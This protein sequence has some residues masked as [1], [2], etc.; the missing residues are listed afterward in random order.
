MI[1][2]KN[3]LNQSTK[4]VTSNQMKFKEKEET[5]LTQRFDDMTNKTQTK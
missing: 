3:S 2:Y 1:K 5:R 4:V